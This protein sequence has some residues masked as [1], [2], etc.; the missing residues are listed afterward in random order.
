[1]RASTSL[2]T[3]QTFEKQKNSE[4]LRGTTRKILPMHATASKIDTSGKEAELY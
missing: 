4:S 3:T 1:M 2:Q